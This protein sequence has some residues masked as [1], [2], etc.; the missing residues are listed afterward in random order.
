MMIY[1]V[2]FKFEGNNVH[3]F[4]PT[5]E[6]VNQAVLDETLQRAKDTIETFF[7][8][9]YEGIIYRLEEARALYNSIKVHCSLSLQMQKF[10]TDERVLCD[11]ISLRTSAKEIF[12]GSD[13]R[14]W[15]NLLVAEML[16]KY[17]ENSHRSSDWSFLKVNDFELH[18][19]KYNP[20]YLYQMKL[21]IKPQ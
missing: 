12:I 17:E 4:Q 7:A 3:F 5:M 18:I 8:H 6:S 9:F 15:L 11:N 20:L 13:L 19:S 16:I 10:T 1:D 21:S 14:E 2:L